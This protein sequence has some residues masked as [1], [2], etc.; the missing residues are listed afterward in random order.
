MVLLVLAV[1][2]APSVGDTNGLSD[3]DIASL[4]QQILWASRAHNAAAFIPQAVLETTPIEAQE[5]QSPEAEGTQS[6]TGQKERSGVG[7]WQGRRALG[8]GVSRGDANHPL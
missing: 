1:F 6:S 8:R 5:A 3:T 7:F 4:R 2:A